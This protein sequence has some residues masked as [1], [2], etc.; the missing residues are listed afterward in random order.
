MALKARQSRRTRSGGSSAELVP[1]LKR[2][3][4]LESN[5]LRWL[6]RLG[7]QVAR[8]WRVRHEDP[9]TLHARWLCAWTRTSFAAPCCVSRGFVIATTMYR[10]E[11]ARYSVPTANGPR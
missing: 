5:D 8:D 2:A 7:R 9:I 3:G 10:A 4:C 1:R 6:L 11:S